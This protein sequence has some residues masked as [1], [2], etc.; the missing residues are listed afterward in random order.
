MMHAFTEISPKGTYIYL[1]LYV[2]NTKMMSKDYVEICELKRQLCKT[3]VLKK[4]IFEVL[5]IL[6]VRTC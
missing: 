5:G 4:S 3:Q 6:K 1:L 2:D